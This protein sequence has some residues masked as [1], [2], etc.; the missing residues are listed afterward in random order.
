MA[1]ILSC[2]CQE[3]HSSL[4]GPL[5]TSLEQTALPVCF[6]LTSSMNTM[7]YHTPANTSIADFALLVHQRFEKERSWVTQADYPAA[8]LFCKRSATCKY[9]CLYVQIELQ[10]GMRCVFI[11]RNLS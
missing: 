6:L 10:A 1:S 11:F 2:Q 3:T 5:M 8:F 9:G 4:K 7:C